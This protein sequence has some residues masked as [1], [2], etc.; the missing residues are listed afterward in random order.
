M[1]AAFLV[2]DLDQF[3]RVLCKSNLRPGA[4]SPNPATSRVPEGRGSRGRRNPLTWL[5]EPDP[6]AASVGR[7]A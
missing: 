5:K 3:I 4:P 6:S 2:A 7:A 1:A